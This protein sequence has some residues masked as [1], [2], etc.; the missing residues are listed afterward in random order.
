LFV[1]GSK[2]KQSVA[3]DPWTGEA[4]KARFDT[5]KAADVKKATLQDKAGVRDGPMADVS[6]HTQ[7]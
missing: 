7:R 5:K 3:I 6:F 4:R 2:S 1:A